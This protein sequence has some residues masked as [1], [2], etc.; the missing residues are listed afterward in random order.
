VP[1]AHAPL[2]LGDRVI[3]AT[4]PDWGTGHVLSAKPDPE[5][6]PQS[7][8]LQVRFQHA[9]MKTLCTA[10]ASLRPV[11][12]NGHASNPPA[13]PQA[14]QAPTTTNLDENPTQTMAALPAA[15]TDP[16]AIAPQR[17]AATLDLYRFT[18]E[19]GSLIEWA[20]LQ[21]GLADPLTRF[22]RHDLEEFFSRY[23]I[24]RDRQLAKV[25]QENMK[26]DPKALA[27]IV[28]A[29]PPAARDALRRINR[30]S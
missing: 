20:T 12:E 3:H 8:K 28:S 19:G 16:F 27:P 23:A 1:Q 29:A 4:K 9:G 10:F 26:T 13:G 6:G 14:H 25:S 21:S 22:S 17:L 2:Q 18:G 11:S 30:R 7:Q 24:H 5:N 15:A